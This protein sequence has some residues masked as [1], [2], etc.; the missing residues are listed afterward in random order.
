MGERLHEK[1][2]QQ[3]YSDIALDRVA[4]EN[5]LADRDDDDD[6]PLT[7]AEIQDRKWLL[8]QNEKQLNLRRAR[9]IEASKQQ[10]A[11]R[12]AKL[13]VRILK[14]RTE[15]ECNPLL[16]KALQTA[17]AHAKAVAAGLKFYNGK[18]CKRCGYTFRFVSTR[19]CVTCS[20]RRFNPVLRQRAKNRIDAAL[21]GMRFFEGTPCRRCGGTKR[22]ASNKN[23]VRCEASRKRVR[24]S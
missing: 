19:H 13:Q 24:A 6:S 10:E 15:R 11:L 7:A 16:F 2:F 8:G 22:Y 5:W 3:S 21:N 17:K 23:C 9:W 1:V 12:D 4:F 20:R 14:Q 18:A